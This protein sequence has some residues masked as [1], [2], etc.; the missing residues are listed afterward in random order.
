MKISTLSLGLLSL[1]TLLSL[2]PVLT[3][4]ANA[5]CVMVDVNTQVAIRGSHNPASQGNDVDMANGE[6]C[7]GNVTV[8]TGTQVS[9]TPGE[10]E[11]S[12][13]SS[14]YVGGSADGSYGLNG[15]VIGVPVNTQVDTYS[16][17]HDPNVI[18]SYKN[19]I[20]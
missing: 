10:V 11:Q 14:H 19:M 16:P 15:P 6:N 17:A 1:P 8:D 12:R 20:D 9:S 13:S 7:F 5:A 3:S 4:Q 18:N 2:T